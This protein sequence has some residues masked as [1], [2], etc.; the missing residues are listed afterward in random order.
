M[1]VLHRCGFAGE[2]GPR[3]IIPSEIQR[4][5]L[6]QVSW[7]STSKC[8]VWL[9]IRSNLKRSCTNISYSGPDG[10]K[11]TQ[12]QVKMSDMCSND[13]LL[14][15]ETKIKSMEFPLISTLLF[16]LCRHVYPKAWAC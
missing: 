9:L 13:Q 5:G 2:T 11:N 7:I 10:G 6:Q 12:S 4:P 3:F 1:S 14:S 15:F 16:I 8:N